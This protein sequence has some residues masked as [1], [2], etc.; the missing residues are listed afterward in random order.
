MS[1]K[2]GKTHK[3][4]VAEN[5][6]LRAELEEALDTL[7]AIRNG[8]VDALIV[9]GAEGEQLFTL[10][11]ANYP[12]RM[13]IED[14]SEGALTLTQDGVILYA[15]H[16]FAEMIKTPLE[17]VI[18][19]TITGWIDSADHTL[20]ET[21][22]SGDAIVSRPPVEVN[23]SAGDGTLTPGLV[24]VNVLQIEALQGCFA[25][26]IT[27]LTEQ[28]RSQAIVASEKL[29]KQLLAETKQSRRALLSVIEDQ[30]AAEEEIRRLNEH[31]EQRVAERTAQL[32]V[33][34]KEL[35]AFA[36][37]VSHDLRAPLR[38]IDGY[39]RILLEDYETTLD[40]EGKRVCGV[41]R[42]QA[43]QMGQLVDNLLA[44]SRLSRAELHTMPIDMTGLVRSA[45][46]ELIT[47]DEHVRLDFRIEDLPPAGGDP[48]LLRQVWMNL[49]ANA[50]KFSSKQARAEIRVGSMV[51]EDETIYYVRD[52]GAGFEMQYA[53]KLFG[54][55]QRL[56]SEKEFEGTGVGLANVQRIIHRH[57]GRV[58]GEGQVGQGACFY[59]ALPRKANVT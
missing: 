33:A 42:R 57:S 4:L 5:A 29:A 45:L 58:W 46:E 48:V 10:A 22:F 52:N 39:T 19:S 18:G 38:A 23:L 31:L 34:N 49:L 47:P 20:F 25:M 14:M 16:R 26:V 8:E 50:L 15:N 17:K 1:G 21:L 27:D 11:G 36:Y 53:N 32:Q 12:Y 2:D 13:L 24:S 59:F 30:K 28:K 3:Q 43:Q 7:R 56:H 40:D 9:P 55:F 51:A 35:E 6:A 44:F 54:V 37:S 41:I